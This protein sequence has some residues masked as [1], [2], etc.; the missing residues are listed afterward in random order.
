MDAIQVGPGAGKPSPLYYMDIL[1]KVQA[2]GKG[3]HISIAPEEV[4]YAL[5]NLSSKGLFIN[6]WT[7]TVEDGYDL[8]KTVVQNSRF[9]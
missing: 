3:L 2:A 9:Y 6:T 8:L 1:K 7:E 4:A 5:D